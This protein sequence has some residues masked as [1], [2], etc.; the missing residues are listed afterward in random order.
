VD[1]ASPP[2]A[3]DP[4]TAT[5]ADLL[6]WRD[7]IVAE[8]DKQLDAGNVD[9]AMVWLR[10]LESA[11][12]DDRTLESTDGRLS[13]IARGRRVVASFDSRRAPDDN[14]VVIVYGNYPHTYANVV[15]NNPIKRHVADFWRFEH[16]A[17]E[18]DRRW[19]GIERIYIINADDRRD[20]LDGVLRELALARAP[21]DR[22]VRIPAVIVDRT[23]YRAASGPIGCVS[24]HLLALRDA[25]S[26]QYA[27]VLVLEDD[28]CFTTDIEQHLDDLREF[29]RRSYDYWICLVATSKYGPVVRRDDLIAESHQVCT[30]T[31]GYLISAPGMRQLLPVYEEAS[32]KMRSTGDTV[33]WAADRCWAV[34]QPSGRFLVFARK[35]GFQNSGYS[36]IEGGMARYLD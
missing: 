4:R 27:N 34:L 10:R 18:S 29:L 31:G 9:E 3:P 22:I 21:F 32:A 20:R 30:N 33:P 16:D 7:A 8:A 36:D 25:I 15:A 35:F 14:E 19:E 26:H 12:I 23:E 5:T 28:F 6:A 13:R 11:T 17:V 1:S 2:T 24:S